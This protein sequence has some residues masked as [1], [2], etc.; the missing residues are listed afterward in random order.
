MVKETFSR[1][2][3]HL[4]YVGPPALS[5]GSITVEM[6]GDDYSQIDFTIV[7]TIPSGYLIMVYISNSVSDGVMSPNSVNYR[8][9]ASVTPLVSPTHIDVT[10]EANLTNVRSI[11]GAKVFVKIVAIETGTGAFFLIGTF[12]QT[13]TSG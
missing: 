4:G 1:T 6:D 2:K 8:L 5:L 10:T 9:V 12:T 7:G 13:V 11:V 3:P